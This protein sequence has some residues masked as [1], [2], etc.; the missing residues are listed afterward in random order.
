MV[1][2]AREIVQRRETTQIQEL[3]DALHTIISNG[4]Y[5]RFAWDDW[6]QCV[7]SILHSLGEMAWTR[8]VFSHPGFDCVTGD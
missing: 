8:R 3:A 4:F 6:V 5:K 2:K 1:H 7:A